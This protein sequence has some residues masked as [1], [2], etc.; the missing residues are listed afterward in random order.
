MAKQ[1]TTTTSNIVELDAFTA[2]KMLGT[3]I[4]KLSMAIGKLEKDG[5]N[6]HSNYQYISNE[7][8]IT[9][10]RSKCLEYQL[11]IIPSVIDYNERDFVNQNGKTT[12]RSIVTM[13]FKLIDLETGHNETHQFIGA[14]QDSGG[15]SMQQAIT[16]CSK[17]FYFKLFK[18]TSHDEIDGDA[19]TTPIEPPKPQPSVAKTLTA[20]QF[21]LAMESDA[22]GIKATIDHIESGKIQANANQIKNLKQ[23]LEKISNN[24]N[25]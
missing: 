19:K 23:Q 13:A 21:K 11:S 3:K 16:Q 4:E 6:Q 1:Q 25:Q 9:A 22:K 7:Q 17:Y 15:K 14:E 18:V 12:T 20:E 24:N 2:Q 10:M 5:R 8:M